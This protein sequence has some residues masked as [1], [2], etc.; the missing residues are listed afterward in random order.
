MKK[1]ISVFLFLLLC[2]SISQA[3]MLI[4]GRAAGMGGAGVAATDDIAAAY[5]NP[6]ALMRS[7]VVVAEAKVDLGAAYT[8]MAALSNALA[9]SSDPATFLLDNYSNNLSFSG[10]LNGLIGLNVRKIGLSVIPLLITTVNKP[11]NSVAGTMT[12]LGFYEP[13]LTVGTTFSVPFLPAA[14]DVGL[15]AK[16]I[17][18]IYGNITTTGTAT[19]ASGVQTVG[20]GSGM[21]Y[22]L[23][24]LT[25][26]EIPFVSKLAVG[27][28][29]R[30]I[31]STYTRTDKQRTAQINQ[32]TGQV[33]YGP[34]T[35][36]PD[37][38]L[39]I[40]NYIP[41]KASVHPECCCYLGRVSIECV[42]TING[43]NY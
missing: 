20:T 33:T 15:N 28:V 35:T 21:G 3:Q 19:N 24:I 13:T 38:N 8:D 29:M 23:G 10:S 14:L 43:G 27:A 18:P 25:T 39:S 17:S 12:A 26:F 7:N 36:L 37:K 6:A 2:V 34:E 22:D 1:A 32:S 31:S 30:D 40:R 16:Q 42:D 4:G 11:A 41:V 5:Y 9:K